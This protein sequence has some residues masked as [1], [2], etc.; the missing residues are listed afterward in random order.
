MC[1]RT[2]LHVLWASP[3]KGWYPQIGWAPTPNPGI[4]I[5][6][7]KLARHTTDPKLAAK[8]RDQV[9]SVRAKNPNAADVNLALWAGGVEPALGGA[10]SGAFGE[11]KSQRTDGAWGFEPD[12]PAREKLGPRGA[13]NVGICTTNILAIASYAMLT[14]NPDAV[15]SLL[16][17]LAAMDQFEIPAGAQVWECPLNEPDILAAAHAVQAELAGYLITGNRHY[18][19]KAIHWAWTGVPFIYQWHPSDRK[20]ML[21]GDTPVFGSSF[22]TWAWMG[23]PVQWCGLAYANSLLE[24]APYDRSF[25]WTRLAASITHCG[26]QE[27]STNAPN[28]GCYP[29]SYHLSSNQP[30][31]PWLNPAIIVGN[32]FDILQGPF[33]Y[34]N[35]VAFARG[36]TRWIVT[37]SAPCTGE[38]SGHSLK[39]VVSPHIGIITRMIVSPPGLNPPTRV[40]L[41]GEAAPKSASGGNGGS[42]WTW[43][44]RDR[45]AIIRVNRNAPFHL[46]INETP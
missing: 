10:R 44:I 37:T 31:G 43:D 35:T 36:G 28:Y 29:D 33:A 22:F 46:V 40:L 38:V 20:I 8:L 3:S 30:F 14:R 19:R 5:Q 24:L 1:A 45:V 25:D 23:R 26:M 18:L 34:P 39:C 12:T 11:M 41:D 7:L 13:T 27:Q 15:R 21:G 42:S 9:H 16:K 4:A 2:F 32:L 17:G 6:M